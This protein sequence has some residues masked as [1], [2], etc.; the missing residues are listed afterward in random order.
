[1]LAV[2]A[3]P[4]IR[5]PFPF[6]IREG[7]V[8]SALFLNTVHVKSGASGF[9]CGDSSQ[10]AIHQNHIF[11]VLHVLRLGVVSTNIVQ[12]FW[13][14][15]Q[16]M[17]RRENNVQILM[18]FF[19]KERKWIYSVLPWNYSIW[20]EL[21]VLS[22]LCIPHSH[23]HWPCMRKQPIKLLLRMSANL[24]LRQAFYRAMDSDLHPMQRA[25]RLVRLSIYNQGSG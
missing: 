25:L 22:A 1:M 4:L 10:N 2:Q 8:C 14:K 9:I 23:V 24:N 21:L 18:P 12:N 20:L 7:N 5:W 6:L 13:L 15:G 19:S 11:W 16:E 17:M 3:N